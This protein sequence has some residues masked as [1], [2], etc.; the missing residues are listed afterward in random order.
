MTSRAPHHADL[1]PDLDTDES[2]LTVALSKR[3]M[4]LLLTLL[5]S[6][7]ALIAARTLYLQSVKNSTLT[8]Y[9]QSQ[10]Q[11]TQLLPAVRGNIVDRNGQEL[12]VGEEAMTFFVTPR[13]MS[14]P[15]ETAAIIART[16][17]L[18][19]D[20][21]SQLLSRL[22]SNPAG[23][24][25]YV[26]R[27]VPSLQAKKLIALK[28]Q[29]DLQLQAHLRTLK[30]KPKK[31][32]HAL[33][34]LQWY[35]EQHRMYPLGSVGAQLLGAVAVSGTDPKTG[36]ETPDGPGVA[37]LEMLY[38]RS[39]SGTSGKQVVVRDPAGTPLD[40][41]SLNPEVDGRDVQLTIDATIQTE[42]ERVLDETMKKYQAKGAT[43][44][45]MN[46]RTGE[47]L[48]MASVPTIDANHFGN[49]NLDWQ[50]NRAITDTYEPGSTFKIVTISAAL[51]DG[52]TTPSR[53]Y[54]L[55]PSIQVADR[56]IKDA[57]NRG[58]MR[59]TTKDI[60]VQSSNVGTITI[61]LQLGKQR[62][63]QWISRYG[64]GKTTGI[65]FPG[66]VRGLVTPPDKWSGS[67]IGNVPIGQGVGVTA[68]QLA[69]AYATIA[70]DGVLVKPHLL[71][72]V[73]GEAMPR[74]SSHRVISARTAQ[75]MRSMFGAV[76]ADERGTGNLAQ[77][78]GYAVAG[79]T[80]TANKAEHGVYVKGKYV[81]S[82]I[83]FVPAQNPQLETLVVV[84]E[85]DVPWGGTVAAPAFEQISQFALQYLAIPPDGIM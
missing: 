36:L 67:T 74:T 82:F 33:S 20:Q 16:L 29:M 65:D 78:P 84:D 50:R 2:F 37:G 42:V 13:L 57:E 12:A 61:G 8:H 56:K 35:P 34:S 81:A 55:P 76:V 71:K 11:D 62:L 1:G 59:M 51:E 19:R 77:I 21:S 39:L 52:V 25:A 64:F 54:L 28:Q 22:T 79:K 17:H 31:P 75:T 69:S 24:F 10:Q 58:T 47:I 43:A 7:I 63:A 15:I 14:D 72:S 45:V 85:P 68:I 30:T 49:A 5:L 70:N 27:E 4:T 6:L 23:G 40:V 3:R 83:G 44:L 41:L 48:A 38:N 80:G 32:V 9:A 46:P 66:E 26:M 53:S 18:S 73:G 60:L